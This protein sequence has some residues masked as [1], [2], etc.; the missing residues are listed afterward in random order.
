MDAL[1]L[2]LE[3]KARSAGLEIDANNKDTIEETI[4]DQDNTEVI[5]N[6]DQEKIKE[7]PSSRDDNGTSLLSKRI[8]KVKLFRVKNFYEFQNYFWLQRFL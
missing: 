5:N 7:K 1:I 3:E 2:G 6:S 8:V 4:Q